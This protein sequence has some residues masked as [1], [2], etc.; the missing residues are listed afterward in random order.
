[1]TTC[2]RCLREARPK[3][4]TCKEC[5]ATESRLAR[6]TKAAMMKQLQKRLEHFEKREAQHKGHK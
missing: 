1:M 5:H 2:S 3:Q 6:V 4:R